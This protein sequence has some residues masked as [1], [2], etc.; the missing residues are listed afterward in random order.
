VG[1]AMNE[2]KQVYPIEKYFVG[3]HS[4][5]GFLTYSLLMNFPEAVAGAIPISCGVIFQCEPSAYDDEDLR[6]AQRE[7]PLA[8]IHGKNDPTV[9]FSQGQY[10]ATLFGDE[11]WPAFRFFTDENAGHMFG[12]LPVGEAIRWLEAQS[13]HDPAVLLDFAERR[14]KSKGYRDAIA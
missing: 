13:S 12:L 2:L 3:G 8:I 9:A 1:E 11:S 7:V 5:G 10:T 4:Q 6:N 14:L